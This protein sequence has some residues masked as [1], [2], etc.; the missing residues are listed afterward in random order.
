[1]KIRFVGKERILLLCMAL[2][3]GLAYSVLA[4]TLSTKP[5]YASSCD[6]IAEEE[7][8][9][10][11]CSLHGGIRQYDCPVQ[12]PQGPAWVVICNDGSFGGELCSS[13]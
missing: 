4:L 3:A 7:D 8:A 2:L 5:V 1:M 13:T 11:V 9:Q 12:A 10:Q 6:C